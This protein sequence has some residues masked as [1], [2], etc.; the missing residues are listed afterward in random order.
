MS[1]KRA[2]KDEK[3]TTAKEAKT[4][5]TTHTPTSSSPS[6]PASIGHQS[7]NKA[8]DDTKDN[9]NRSIEEAGKNISRNTNYQM[10]TIQAF[11][12]IMDSYLQYQKEIVSSLQSI[13]SPYIENAYNVFY[14]FYPS[15]QMI[16]KLYVNTVNGFVDNLM[17]MIKLANS[18]MYSNFDTYKAVVEQQTKETK[19]FHE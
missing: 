14:T 15:P 5:S 4:S 10:Q 12:E 2:P 13:W 18:V 3:T 9:I 6:S 7:V 8:L 11:E 16:S 19:S 17:A 1:T